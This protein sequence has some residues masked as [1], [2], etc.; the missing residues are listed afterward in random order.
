[1]KTRRCFGFVL[2]LSVVVGSLGT[3]TMAVEPQ[4][5]AEPISA[6]ERASGHFGETISAGKYKK[7]GSAISLQVGETVNFNASY[8][9]RSVSVDFGVIDSNNVFHYINVTSGSV[10]GGVTVTESGQY[11]P[12]IRN[13]SSSDSIYVTGIIECY[14]NPN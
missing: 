7:I 11:T 14:A 9:P 13:N 4:N 10:D 3:S 12:A 1:M 2:A 5:S 8:S 6:I